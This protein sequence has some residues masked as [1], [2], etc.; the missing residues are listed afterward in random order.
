MDS[1]MGGERAERNIYPSMCRYPA[2]SAYSTALATSPGLDPQVPR[3]MAGM[4]APVLR[5]KVF[6]QRSS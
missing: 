3:P 4:V 5:V 2:R 6:L 1:K